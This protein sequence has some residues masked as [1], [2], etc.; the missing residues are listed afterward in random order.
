MSF[1]T[2]LPNYLAN[3]V[4]NYFYSPR[5]ANSDTHEEVSTGTHPTATTSG[6][7]TDP[8]AHT[9]SGHSSM[10]M[11]MIHDH[12]QSGGVALASGSPMATNITSN[13]TTTRTRHRSPQGGWC[14]PCRA[15]TIFLGVF[16]TVVTVSLV[17]VKKAD[18]KHW[19][20]WRKTFTCDLGPINQLQTLTQSKID[21]GGNTTAYDTF[22]RFVQCATP[23][24]RESTDAKQP[25][26]FW[27]VESWIPQK[28]PFIG[29][30]NDT[31]YVIVEAS[32]DQLK[33]QGMKTGKTYKR[34]EASG[35]VTV[36]TP[37]KL[38]GYTVGNEPFNDPNIGLVGTLFHRPNETLG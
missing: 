26:S 11:M 29:M 10:P 24:L 19:D 32:I 25:P 15:C 31:A 17:Y 18:D 33:G 20:N 38:I 30:D 22:E 2:A 5:P 37:T 8:E 13:A 7:H 14:T 28:Y 12:P 9:T 35:M 16:I 27:D 36:N 3:S 34:N 23:P 21:A 4:N 6:S 1:L